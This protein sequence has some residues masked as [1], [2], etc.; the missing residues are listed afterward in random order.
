MPCP[1]LSR[2]LS[3]TPVFNSSR[4]RVFVPFHIRGFIDR[5]LAISESD[6]SNLNLFE[7]FSAAAYCPNNNNDVA[8]G[9]KL[10]C[11]TG[12][13]PLVDSSDVTTVY[14]FQKYVVTSSSHGVYD[15]MKN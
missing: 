8:G 15:V 4:Y 2:W 13:C 3:G 12:N 6:Y 14:E 10:S 7:Q 1:L 5:H 9:T 11:P